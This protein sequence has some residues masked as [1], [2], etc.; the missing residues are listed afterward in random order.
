MKG[1]NNLNNNSFDNKEQ[2]NVN[3][4][5]ENDK[6]TNCQNVNINFDKL[7]PLLKNVCAPFENKDKLLILMSS[8]TVISSVLP[9][10]FG[11][12][13]Q[14]TVYPNIMLYVI[15]KAGS[16]KGN[17]TWTKSLIMYIERKNVSE[18]NSSSLLQQLL[19]N[20]Y[21]E[22]R[23]PENS[24]VIIPANSSSSAFIGM[25]NAQDGKGLVFESEGDT[26]ANIFKTDY[27]NWSDILRKVFHH[28]SVSQSRKTDDEHI[29]IEEPQLSVAISSTP[30]QLK[31]IISDAENGLF[32][33]FAFIF[34]E[35]IEEF[36]DVFSMEGGDIKKTFDIASQDLLILY[37]K[38]LKSD[39]TEILLHSEQKKLFLEFFNIAKSQLTNLF[40]E[41]LDASV[42]RMGLIVLR[43]CMVLTVLRSSKS[44]AK[45]SLI[46]SDEDFYTAIK[47]G[48]TLLENANTAIQLLPKQS[49]DG[50]SERKLSLFQSLPDEFTTALAKELGG[51][52][53]ISGRTVDRFLT[54][55]CF[56]SIGHGN[57]KK[58]S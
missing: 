51:E 26:L 22:E 35:P 32:S 57:W 36:L 13:N 2:N 33:R 56:Q 41:D 9:N 31:R 27:G 55:A 23:L 8:L 28:E 4:Q 7:P 39:A 19:Q 45:E 48:E 3:N 18:V 1:R 58:A 11:K 52:Y 34:T 5:N 10:V 30:N 53:G 44:D 38:L 25:L 43:I 49:Q 40:S 15:G 42:N 14:Q 21:N 50:V 46:C 54:T 37:N 29:D 16:G 20:G 24:K 6:M 47:L 12:Y 17:M